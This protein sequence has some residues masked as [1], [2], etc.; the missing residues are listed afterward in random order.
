MVSAQNRQRREWRDPRDGQVWIVTRE[1]EGGAIKLLF[2][3][4]DEDEPSYRI[5]ID[6]QLSLTR[7]SDGRIAELLDQARAAPDRR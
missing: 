2:R 3:A 4:L 7:T 1:E 5:A 6:T